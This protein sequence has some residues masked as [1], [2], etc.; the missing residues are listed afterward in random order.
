MSEFGGLWKHENN[1]HAL[2]PPKTECGCPN[3]GGIK[4]ITYATPPM[5]ERGKKQ[6][7][8]GEVETEENTFDCCFQFSAIAP[9]GI[10]SSKS[11]TET[12]ENVVSVTHGME[13]LPDMWMHIAPS[14]VGVRSSGNSDLAWFPGT[15]HSCPT[16]GC[17]SCTDRWV[18]APAAVEI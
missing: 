16:C 1:Q 10:M 5:E 17:T 15:G 18:S 9:S 14:Q 8:T 11:F 7:K 4:T 13:Q 2:V 3:G 12:L 6:H